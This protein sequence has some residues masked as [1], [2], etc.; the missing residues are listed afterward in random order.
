MEYNIGEVPVNFHPVFKAINALGFTTFFRNTFIDTAKGYRLEL[1]IL[2]KGLQCLPSDTKCFPDEY[3][4]KVENTIYEIDPKTISICLAFI[5]INNGSRKRGEGT[6]LLQQ[7]CSIIDE[8]DYP[9]E[10]D[11]D[12]Q[13][14]TPENALYKWYSSFDF[15]S[16]GLNPPST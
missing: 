2:R 13:F 6:K 14:G 4:Y 15:V 12:I 9:I 16:T 8:Y 11:I 1:S 5:E 7:V 10:L 3:H